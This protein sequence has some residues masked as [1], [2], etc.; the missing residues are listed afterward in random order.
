LFEAQVERT[1][2]AVAVVYEE[3]KLTYAE[4]NRRANQLAWYLKGEGV[5]PEVRVGIC[6]ERSLEM[7]VG[8]LGI[9]KAGGA[10]VPL[11]PEYPAERLDYMLEDAQVAVLLTQER[12]GQ[13]AGLSYAGRVI[14]WEQEG[15]A[16]G[17]QSG[18]NLVSGVGREN[19]AY[20]IYTSGSTGRPKAVGIRHGSVAVLLNWAQEV[21]SEEETAGVLASTSMCFDLSV[22]EIFVPLSRGGRVLIVDN[23]LKLGGMVDRETVTL[24]NTVPSAMVELVRMKAVPASV[25]VVNLAGEALSRTLVKQVYEQ[26]TIER[27]FNLYGPSEDTTY[28]TFEFLDREEQAEAVSIGKPISNS[29]VYVLDESYEAVPVGVAGELYIGGEGLARGYVNRPEM[30]AEKFVPNPFS[31]V[32]G[33]RLYRTGDRVKWCGGGNLEFLGRVDHQV[34]LR[35]YRIELGEIENALESHEQV[36]RAVVLM[37][38][39]QPGAKQLVGYVA[40]RAGVK[41]LSIQELRSHLTERL[42]EYMVPAAWVE[43]ESFPLTSNGKIDYKKLSQPEAKE[44]MA[45][46]RDSIELELVRIFE[47]VLKKTG[48]GIRDNFFD[49]GGHSLL[50]VQLEFLIKQRLK[51]Q[52]PLAMLFRHPSVEGLAVILRKYWAGPSVLGASD[53]VIPGSPIVKVKGRGSRPPLFFVHGAG[54]SAFAFTSLARHLHPEQPLLAFQDL[55]VEDA[56]AGE[57]TIELMAMQ[58]VDAMRAVQPDGPYLLG[59]WSMGGVVAFEMARQL[60]QQ[61]QKVGLLALVDSY[62]PTA[63]GKGAGTQEDDEVIFNA[64]L[65]TLGFSEEAIETIDGVYE[66]PDQRMARVQEVG[67]TAGLL[68]RGMDPAAARRLFDVYRRHVRA[69]EKFNPEPINLVARLWNAQEAV[70]LAKRNLD[71]SGSGESPISRQES[72]ETWQ[73]YTAEVQYGLVP[74]NHL[75]L[76][77]EPHAQ[78]LAEELSAACLD[79]FANSTVDLGLSA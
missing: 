51:M 68:P 71:S 67:V 48:V 77:R 4:L 43:L 59:G 41:V 13:K 29:K 6:V 7:I 25:R 45:G 30:T 20:L 38:E 54:G 57:T 12:A 34:K 65:G 5:G 70:P 58:Y 3:E 9:L 53:S 63:G 75:T 31:S 64:F 61:N 79:V 35:G 32:G 74:G 62:L 36:Q 10:Y 52:L 40:K 18:E 72:I 49:L 11:D 39:D 47:E 69:L 1:P 60:Q 33:E 56:N 17:Q 76:L 66:T 50:A 19:L 26:R 44:S 23:A 28:S 22:F 55:G 21:F 8:L 27:V 73:N 2:A 37:R 78:F 46:P 24:V 42:P 14:C 15:A 16:I